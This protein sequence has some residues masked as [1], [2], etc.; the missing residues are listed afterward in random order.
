VRHNKNVRSHRGRDVTKWFHLGVL[1]AVL[2]AALVVGFD[3]FEA[4][5]HGWLFAGLLAGFAASDAR[6]WK[7]PTT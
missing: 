7:R 3:R 4:H 1:L 2:A 5:L 6:F